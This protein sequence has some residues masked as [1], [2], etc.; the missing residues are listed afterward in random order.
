ME[1]LQTFFFLSD[2]L[3]KGWKAFLMLF[4][5]LAASETPSS[6]S[7]GDY[8]AYRSWKPLSQEPEV[9]VSKMYWQPTPGVTDP[10]K[11]AHVMQILLLSS[12]LL[13]KQKERQRAPAIYSPLQTMLHYGGAG[14]THSFL[15]EAKAAQIV[16]TASALCP[17]QREANAAIPPST[18]P[19][20]H[21]KTLYVFGEHNSLCI[22]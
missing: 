16:F 11:P 9:R 10:H 14:G 7:E 17:S 6:S 22:W 2:E 15:Q 8:F 3:C 19:H 12:R 20:T 5:I 1:M 21:T 13:S 4:F 18:H